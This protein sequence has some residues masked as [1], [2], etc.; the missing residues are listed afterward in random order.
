ME[1][2]RLVPPD[3]NYY[4]YALIDP[5]DN[6]IFYIGKGKN[7]RYNDHK[8]DDNRDGNREK[9]NKIKAIK[10]SG[11]KVRVVKLL[12]YLNEEIAFKIEEIL[13]YNIGRKAFYEGSLTNFNKGGN[14][15]LD[16]S[17]FYEKELNTNILKYYKNDFNPEFKKCLIKQSK[18]IFLS[19][20]KFKVFEYDFKGKLLRISDSI[21]F[22]EESIFYPLFNLF[23]NNV[24]SVIFLN[25]II[26]KE[27]LTSF[28]PT[29]YNLFIHSYPYE[30]SFFKTLDLKIDQKIDFKIEC[31]VNE[32][33]RLI[34]ERIDYILTYKSFINGIE[35]DYH[36]GN[37]R[38][39][40]NFMF[41]TK[42]NLNYSNV[43]K[44]TLTEEEQK[45]RDKASAD[46]EKYKERLQ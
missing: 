8:I 45:E 33:L 20:L 28:Y 7:Q 22:F 10:L 39:K 13:I 31:Q 32:N 14:Y 38:E 5:R 2:F 12:E 30:N 43:Q 3:H 44:S 29:K 24:A 26:S 1:E 37:P 16:D 19:N 15:S 46:W 11:N 17:L 36:I 23:I 25:K 35:N 6:E 42:D 21:K 41:L 18:I 27:E 34:A 9:K 4:V 40:E